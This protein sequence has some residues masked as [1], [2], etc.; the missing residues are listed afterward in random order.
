MATVIICVDLDIEMQT[1]C[2]KEYSPFDY[3]HKSDCCIILV[4]NTDVV[5]KNSISGILWF[6][7][8][9]WEYDPLS[10]SQGSKKDLMLFIP[11]FPSNSFQ[12]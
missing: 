6:L 4:L 10:L 8:Y 2:S 5:N 1:I 3:V 9:D 11:F 7:L 12:V